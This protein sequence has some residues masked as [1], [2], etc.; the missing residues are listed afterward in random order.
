MA[1]LPRAVQAQ[2][3]AAD[4]VLAQAGAA[5]GT[6]VGGVPADLEQLAQTPTEPPI[7]DAPTAQEPVVPEVKQE[8]P[9]PDAW[10]SKYKTLQGLFNAEV[11]KLQGQVKELTSRLNE[12]I[13]QLEKTAKAATPE[14]QKASVDPKDVEAFGSD[15]VEMVQRVAQQ[16]LGGVAA[17]VDGVVAGFEQRVSA[18]EQAQ[19]ATSQTV[20]VTAEDA[21]FNRLTI[22]VPDWEQVNGDERFLAWLGEV[23]PLL[24]QPRQAAL[25]AAQQ[26]LNIERTVAIFNAF[27]STLPQKPTKAATAVEKQISPSTAATAAPTPTEK[28]VITQAQIQT[29][30][31]DVAKGKYR[32]RDAEVVKLEQIINQAIAEGR[33]R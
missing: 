6:G 10:E 26:S 21:F 11:P 23:D 31:A 5:Q 15:L 32:G 33:V 8:A 2:V 17:K 9:K 27:K 18:L 13:A 29:F 28:P 3:E 4:A 16:M 7:A 25:T 24:G 20:A 22:Q 19:K 30:Y 12:A 14:P 1:N